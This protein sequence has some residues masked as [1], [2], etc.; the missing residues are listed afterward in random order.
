MAVW[1]GELMHDC[2]P[3]HSRMRTRMKW[4]FKKTD[5]EGKKRGAIEYGNKQRGRFVQKQSMNYKTNL[6]LHVKSINCPLGGKV[7]VLY[8]HTELQ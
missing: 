6:T 8:Q 4:D 2:F 5:E 7:Y 1:N 3:K